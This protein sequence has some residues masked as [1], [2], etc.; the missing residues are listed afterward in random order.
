MIGTLN[1]KPISAKF[2]RDTDFF[3]K[4]DPYCKVKLGNQE[5]KS[6]P[7]EGGGK[8]PNFNESTTLRVSN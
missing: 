1:F 8:T 7:H 3:S 5:W 2:K 6:K 4:M